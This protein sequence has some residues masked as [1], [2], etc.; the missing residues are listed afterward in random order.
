VSQ[1]TESRQSWTGSFR[2][3]VAILGVGLLL[4]GAAIWSAMTPSIEGKNGVVTRFEAVELY[5]KGRTLW[6]NRSVDGLYNATRHFEEA[7][8]LDPN[9]AL[10]H[11]A[12]ADAYVFDVLAWRKAEA[13]ANEAIRLDPKLGQPYATIGFVRMYW[14]QRLEDAE[15]YFKKAIELDPDYATARQWYALNLTARSQGGSGLAEMKRAHELDPTSAA[16]N[17]D[18]CQILYFARKYDQAIEHC[19]KAIEIEANFLTPRHHLYDIYTAMEM[20]DAAVNEFFKA[21]ELNM[22]SAAFP[23]Q[24]EQ[25]TQ[26][27]ANGGI[28]QF[29]QARVGMLE[30]ERRILPYEL[31]KYYARLGKNDNALRAFETA[32]ERHDFD[33]LFFAVDPANRDVLRLLEARKL[34]ARLSPQ[35]P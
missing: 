21:Q 8:A 7:I 4:T 16:I 31:G 35:E 19:H 11:A 13:V 10:A 23:H 20:Y 30:G 5:E 6:Q 12:L 14:E 15:P 28:R 1:F 32:A 2:Y 33:F 26:A 18:M 24:H 27:Y 29:W 9:F 22:T 3:L 34:K 17:A 25:L